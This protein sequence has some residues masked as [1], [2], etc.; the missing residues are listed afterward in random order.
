MR[1]ERI[2]PDQVLI[3]FDNFAERERFIL[4]RKFRRVP[5]DHCAARWVSPPGGAAPDH[6][7][8]LVPA[9][10]SQNMN[11]QCLQMKLVRY[12]L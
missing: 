3:T 11:R 2:A 12:K 10:T 4:G 1:T 7:V 8:D 9:M 5:G 6:H